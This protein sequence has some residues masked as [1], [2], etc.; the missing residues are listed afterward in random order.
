MLN[1]RC[2]FISIIFFISINLSIFKLYPQTDKSISGRNFRITV[3]GDN[4]KFLLLGRSDDKS[5]FIP[6]IFNEE[7]PEKSNTFF[8]LMMDN[9]IVPLGE[10]GMGRFRDIWTEDNKIF[11]TW[12]NPSVKVL[13]S[14]SLIP[15][16]V[17][18]PADTLIIDFSVTSNVD[19]TVTGDLGFCIDTYLGE[20]GKEHFVLPGN[21]SISDEYE[22]S[23]EMLPDFV[24]SYDSSQKIGLNILFNRDGQ[25]TPDRVFFTNWKRYSDMTGKHQV[26]KG[27]SFFLNSYS[28]NDSACIIEYTDRKYL[29]GR[30]VDY[31]FILSMKAELSTINKTSVL[32]GGGKIESTI[33]TIEVKKDEAPLKNQNTESSGISNVDLK[34]ENLNLLDLF[35]LLDIINEKLESTVIT[36]E[37]V[38]LSESILLEISKRR[39]R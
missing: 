31:R 27:R 22:M 17:G 24:T 20:K 9:K 39:I 10:G 6:L 38:T 11:Y 16:E 13:I 29:P 18:K 36:D 7:I 35:K 12:T 5:K 19:K 2:L 28:Q 25:V 4:G 32:P 37:D 1:N 14:Y 30:P 21:I 15:S 26:V 3:S 33:E 8:R 34:F 23:G